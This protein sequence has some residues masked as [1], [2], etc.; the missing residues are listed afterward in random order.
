MMVMTCA[1]TFPAAIHKRTTTA[2]WHHTHEVKFS[3]CVF[4]PLGLRA[5][6][7]G[8]RIPRA[9][10]KGIVLLSETSRRTPGLKQGDVLSPL[11]FNFPLEYAIR[12]VQ[13]NHDSWKLN[14]TQQLL[15]HAD[16]VNILGGS[17][18]TYLLHGAEPFLRS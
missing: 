10:E 5:G 16:G 8:V 18:Y 12:R 2:L 3:I 11:L 17:V 4:S 7:C 6:R 14:G 15:F 1:C 9:D 13:V